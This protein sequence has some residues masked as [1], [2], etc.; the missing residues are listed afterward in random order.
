MFS[1]NGKTYQL[2]V[3]NG[4][5]HL[6]GGLKGFDKKM[7]TLKSSTDNSITFEL[8]SKDQ[9]ENYPGTLK[10]VVTYTVTETNEL[11]IEYGAELIENEQKLQTVVNLT[12]HSY[13][14]LNGCSTAEGITI[15]NHIVSM[16]SVK[17]YLPKDENNLPVGKIEPTESTSE[18]DFSVKEHTVG[19]RIASGKFDGYDHCYVVEPDESK[20][21]IKGGQEL[22][23]LVTVKSPVTNI[24]L[25]F[26]T[27]EP[28]FQL[29]SGNFLDNSLQ[30]KQTQTYHW[31]KLH[32]AKHSGLCLESQRFPNA[33][34]NDKW[35]KQVILSNGEKYWQKTSYK[36]EIY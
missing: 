2:A 5:N 20:W 23:Q 6:H 31:P 13:F 26:S 15:L 28:G 11:V 27:T 1:L 9:E 33:I 4:P 12:N 17:H 29:Y 36:F 14:N 19:E 35:K 16:P 25:T 24:K 34:N 32:L 21:G 8:I 18:M 30:T 22:K 3:N 7:W 10:S